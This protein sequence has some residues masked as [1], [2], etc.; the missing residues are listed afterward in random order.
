M[1]NLNSVLV[2]GNVVADPDY[3][4]TT[5]GTPVCH[6]RLGS[7][8]Y[9][10]VDT[11]LQE[12]ANFFDVETWAKSAERCR[13]ALTKGRN[14]RVVGRLKQD[15]W[16]DEEGGKHAR[17]KIVADHVDIGPMPKNKQE[18]EELPVEVGANG[19][20][21]ASPNGAAEAGANGA[22]DASGSAEAGSTSA[23]KSAEAVVAEAAKSGQAGSG[24]A[25]SGQS[26]SREKQE[27]PF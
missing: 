17:V 14:V 20:A 4:E 25:K 15:R 19:I 1:N 22:A 13:D 6:F 7:N 16:T 21:Q 26:K 23:A 11:E 5:K 24:Q 2:D 8:R 3:R 27:V 10:R 12:E 18:G 9:Y